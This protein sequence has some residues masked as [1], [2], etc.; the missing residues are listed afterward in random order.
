MITTSEPGKTAQRKNVSFEHV[1][2]PLLI[3]NVGSGISIILVSQ[4]GDEVEIERVGGTS[5]G[6]AFFMGL[7]K[8]L[9]GNYS[10]T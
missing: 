9:V 6:G 10:F 4:I 7:A 5:L 1:K 3:V 8:Y 2:L